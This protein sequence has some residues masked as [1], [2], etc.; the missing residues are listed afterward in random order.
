[1]AFGFDVA[2]TEYAVGS[3]AVEGNPFPLFHSRAGRIGGAFALS[4]VCAALD[5]ELSR[6]GHKRLARGLRVAFF[7]SRVALAAWNIDTVNDWASGN[8]A[9][10]R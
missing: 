8:S 10:R 3:G 4:G 9:A 2:S 6:D 7:A 1:M 5:T